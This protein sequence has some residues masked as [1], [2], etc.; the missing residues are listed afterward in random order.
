[1]VNR[2][3]YEVHV[4]KEIEKMLKDALGRMENVYDIIP[5]QY[6]SEL[7]SACQSVESSLLLLN[8]PAK[9]VDR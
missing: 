1:M 3:S 5:L 4:I 7:N 2:T 9:R 8:T 6:Q